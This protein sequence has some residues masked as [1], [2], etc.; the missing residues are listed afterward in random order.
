M[1]Q[2]KIDPILSNLL[3]ETRSSVEPIQV[4]VV[5]KSGLGEKPAS[6]SETHEAAHDLIHRVEQ[7]TGEAP[8][9]YNVFG[10]L[11]SFAIE[12]TPNFIRRLVEKD[13]VASAIANQQPGS[14]GGSRPDV[15]TPVSKAMQQPASSARRAP[16]L[17][18]TKPTIKKK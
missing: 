12:A 5:L 8:R 7:E 1:M 15:E 4:V 17:K 9:R 13:E 3:Q 18:R 16:A 6:S 14:K 11:S 2:P 10:N